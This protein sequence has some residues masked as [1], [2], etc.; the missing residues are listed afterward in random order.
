MAYCDTCGFSCQDTLCQTPNCPEYVPMDEVLEW[1]AADEWY[2][3]MLLLRGGA[4]GQT[5]P[6]ALEECMRVEDW[7]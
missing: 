7:C 3:E 6:C 2:E 5:A 4:A 1:S